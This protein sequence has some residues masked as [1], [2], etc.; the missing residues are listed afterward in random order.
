MSRCSVYAL[1]VLTRR[2]NGAPRGSGL[3]LI[4]GELTEQV[5][6]PA[7]K[8]HRNTGPGLLEPVY[9]QFL[10]HELRGAGI[11]F[12]RQVAIPVIYKAMPI[13]EGFRAESS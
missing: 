11:P 10:C 5:I 8:V 9:E 13:G 2:K 3:V 12:E 6:E 7:F 1:L 4:G